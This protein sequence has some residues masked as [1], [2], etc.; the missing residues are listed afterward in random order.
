MPALRPSII[1]VLTSSSPATFA[2]TAVALAKFSLVI[3]L[4]LY[5]MS[6]TRSE[7]IALNLIVTELLPIAPILKYLT[8]GATV[9]DGNGIVDVSSSG[10]HTFPP[11][12][13]SLPLSVVPSL[14]GPPQEQDEIVGTTNK[15]AR[16]ISSTANHFFFICFPP[17]KI[18]STQT[19]FIYISRDLYTNIYYNKTV[20]LSRCFILI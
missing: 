4:S 19:H 17:K 20:I 7:P 3:S 6:Y 1:T 13:P 11:P 10:S 15:T 5:L 8:I 9:P 12:S 18:L 14:P 16:T 2:V